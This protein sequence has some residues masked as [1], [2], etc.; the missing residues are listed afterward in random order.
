MTIRL[1]NLTIPA[2]QY[3]PA[4]FG[5]VPLLHFVLLTRTTLSNSA[6]LALS[7]PPMFLVALLFSCETE[8]V[9]QMGLCGSS[10]AMLFRALEAATCPRTVNA[11]WSFRDYAEFMLTSDNETLRVISKAR[12]DKERKIRQEKNLPLKPPKWK[13]FTYTAQERGLAF[14][15]QFLVRMMVTI[16]IYIYCRTALEKYGFEHRVG[17]VAPW[18]VKSFHD[19][20]CYALLVYAGLEFGYFG[21]MF[22]VATILRTPLVYIFHY[23]HLSTS[24]RDFW[25]YRWNYAVKEILHRLSFLQTLSLL[26]LFISGKGTRPPASHCAIASLAA[27]L[28]SAIIH[29]YLVFLF[30]EHRFGENTCFFLLQAVF[31]FAQVELQ[32]ATGFGRT[33]GRGFFGSLFGWTCT[34]LLLLCT[35]PLFI[36]PYARAGF[37][38]HEMQIPV[39]TSIMDFAK[40]VI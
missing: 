9:Q 13:P 39:P 4:V 36:G 38:L 7:L 33:W 17:F 12:D 37:L 2:W 26:A 25:S 30:L 10:I 40:T 16:L 23:P 11:A 1:T 31:C 14:Y 15:V 19:H 6:V 29:E 18:D 22:I 20:I 27:F 8:L 35:S 34:M 28:L 3:L 5:A 32:R 24:P 21:T